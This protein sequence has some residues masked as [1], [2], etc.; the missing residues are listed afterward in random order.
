MLPPCCPVH[1]KLAGQHCA[2]NFWFVSRRRVWPHKPCLRM[3]SYKCRCEPVPACQML[4]THT[5]VSPG[6]ERCFWLSF[7]NGREGL[8]HL[9]DIVKHGT[10]KYGWHGKKTKQNKNKSLRIRGN[11]LGQKQKSMPRLP[12]SRLYN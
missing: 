6:R 4:V 8:V 3:S 5:I 2:C 12:M 1:T 9:S 10:K 11:V 7:E